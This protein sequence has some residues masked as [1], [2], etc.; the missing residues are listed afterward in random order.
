[1]YID[2]INDGIYRYSAPYTDLDRT[3]L[4]KGKITRSGRDFAA[5]RGVTTFGSQLIIGDGER[6]L[7]WNEFADVQVHEHADDVWGQETFDA[8]DRYY[9]LEI[10]FPTVDEKN[11]LW[12]SGLFRRGQEVKLGFVAFGYPLTHDSE[13][14]KEVWDSYDLVDHTGSI[15]ITGELIGFA[16]TDGGDQLW[17]ADTDN[18]RAIRVNNVDGGN[19]PGRGPYVD[20]VLGQHDGTSTQANQGAG[21]GNPGRDTMNR[22]RSITFDPSGNLYVADSSGEGGTNRRVLI[23]AGEL[24][25]DPLEHVLYAVP[26]TKV[27]GTCGNFDVPGCV[28]ETCGPENVALDRYSHMVAGMGPYNPNVE[29]FSLLYFDPDGSGRP[30]MALG[31]YMANPLFNHFDAQGNLYIGDYNWSR[32]LI[33]R[34]PMLYLGRPA[35]TGCEDWKS[36]Y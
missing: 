5:P 14:V 3:L 35:P 34:K 31:D 9:Q 6:L 17:I 8:N 30:Q 28:D 12:I 11:R 32:V 16:L 10:C 23:F 21:F 27:L 20:V 19:D 29:R 22:P 1:V 7:I 4:F 33:W 18:S 13:P 26:A 15:T 36:Y 25:P 2:I 24:F